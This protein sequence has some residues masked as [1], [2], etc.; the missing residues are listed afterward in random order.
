MTV[1]RGPFLAECRDMLAPPVQPVGHDKSDSL[2][3]DLVDGEL[4]EPV[5]YLDYLLGWLMS[6]LVHGSLLIVLA[7][8]FLPRDEPPRT[9]TVVLN[10]EVLEAEAGFDDS[11]LAR[12]E[13]P[14][15]IDSD[16]PVDT[17][18]AAL[19]AVAIG[20]TLSK[21]VV[22]RV[23]FTERVEVAP[24]P[25]AGQDPRMRPI[26]RANRDSLKG[27]QAGRKAE[28]L[29]LRGGNEQSEGAVLRGLRWL[30]AHQSEDGAWRF[31]HQDGL[32][33]G[34]CRH[35]GDFPSSTASTALALL[36]FYG[37]G[38]T[39]QDGEFKEAMFRGLYYLTK[40]MYLTDNGADFR[41]GS[42]YSQGLVTI[43][44]CE[45]Y[46]M[47]GDRSVGRY[48]QSAIDFVQNAQHSAGGWR[49]DPGEPGDMTITGWQWMGLKSGQM[50]GL[51]VHSGALYNASSFLDSLS[52]Y[53]GARYGYI[54]RSSRQTTTA[55]GLLLRM[56]EG[57]ARDDTR[58]TRGVEYL[59]SL[60]P[61]KKNIYFN[62]YATQLLS[63][64][65]GPLW[66]RWNRQMRNRL[67]ADQSKIG[68]EA[69]SWYYADKHSKDGGRLYNTAMAIMTL[70]VYYRYLP[71]Y[72]PRAA[73]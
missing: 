18:P 22:P 30:V 63:H 39:H 37:A 13:T 41:E 24:R 49:Y 51:N 16:F 29:Q 11:H 55:I 66:K 61:S 57:W 10:E 7:L 47:T 35:P 26:Y 15:A 2:R 48:A 3:A 40:A 54:D 71:L 14:E 19:D 50:A 58:L 34:Q 25:A 42:M 33:A 72:S 9:M 67:V 28:L 4:V 31:N 1:G 59:A 23:E 52:S 46:A 73:E 32:C 27:R 8:I 5:S 56:Y 68:H 21:P 6:T 69:G 60:G 53:D 64:Y 38:Y 65:D 43:V 45:A 12:V 62:Y 44:L 20:S 17:L 70:E 36:P